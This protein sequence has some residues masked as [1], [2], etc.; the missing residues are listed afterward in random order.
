M[1]SMATALATANPMD[2]TS[3]DEFIVWS[4][5]T[6][7]TATKNSA[8]FEANE[9]FGGLLYFRRGGVAEC[10]GG[11]EPAGLQ[12]ARANV[13]ADQDGGCGRSEFPAGHAFGARSLGARL[14]TRREGDLFCLRRGCRTVA[15]FVRWLEWPG[16]LGV[17]PAIGKRAVSL[18]RFPRRRAGSE[19]NSGKWRLARPCG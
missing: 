7:V 14:F 16:G 6:V 9:G 15:Q 8:S 11:F 3:R 12:R 18:A 4:A 13:W 10:A 2:Q 17:R 5:A 19:G 1:V